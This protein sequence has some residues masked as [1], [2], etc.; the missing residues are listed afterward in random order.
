[1]VS[2]F[3]NI[4]YSRSQLNVAFT[5]EGEHHSHKYHR[6]L[7]STASEILFFLAYLQLTSLLSRQNLVHRSENGKPLDLKD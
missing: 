1:M 5:S 4:L 2:R 7:Y 6:C 3:Q